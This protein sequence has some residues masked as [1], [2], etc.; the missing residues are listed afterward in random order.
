[1]GE[2]TTSTISQWTYS[3]VR[4]RC[5]QTLLAR[6]RIG[7]TCLTQRYLIT[8]DPQP[9]C[10]DCL[11]PLTVRHLLVQCPSLIELRHRYLYRC[12]GRYSGVYYISKVLGPECLAQG[13]DVLRFLGEAGLLQKL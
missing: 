10:D 7:H 5:I 13:H 3:H 6:L 12:R 2:I 4:D 1:M 9:Y 11:V 8:R